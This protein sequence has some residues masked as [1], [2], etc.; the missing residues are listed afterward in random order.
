MRRQ[1]DE[2]GP[3]LDE[4]REQP[5][6]DGLARV[7]HVALPPEGGLLEEPGQ[8]SRVV[9][10]EVGDQEEVN[11]VGLDHVHEREGVHAA[12]TCKKAT[13]READG[14]YDIPRQWHSHRWTRGIFGGLGV[15]PWLSEGVRS[16][17]PHARYVGTMALINFFTCVNAA[18]EKD[19]LALEL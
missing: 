13:K 1:F 17:P 11:L 4:I 7:G 5:P 14:R 8:R 9:Q 2:F 6:Y 3:H 16:P 15:S 19:P 10:M 18:V 12:K